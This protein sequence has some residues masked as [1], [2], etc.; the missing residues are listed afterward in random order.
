MQPA[1][2]EAMTSRMLVQRTATDL[3]EVPSFFNFIIPSS[4]LQICFQNTLAAQQSRTDRRRI[5][6]NSIMLQNTI[7]VL[8]SLSACQ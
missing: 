7:G 1:P 5:L 6:D 4:C 2:R 8:Q 3:R